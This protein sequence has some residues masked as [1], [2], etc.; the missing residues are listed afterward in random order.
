MLNKKGQEGVIVTIILILVA[1]AAVAG[2][3][4]FIMS[5]VN[6]AKIEAQNKADC[7]KAT[8]TIAKAIPTGVTI[9]RGSDSLTLTRIDLYVDGTKNSATITIPASL[10][11]KTTLVTLTTGQKVRVNAV[12]N[13]YVCENGPESI[14]T[15]S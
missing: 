11:S 4:V 2:I 3:A 7:T 13:G 6:S 5:Q 8:L 12:V 15:A 14:V 9:A 10:E 1:I